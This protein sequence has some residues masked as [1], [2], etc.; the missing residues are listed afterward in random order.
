MRIYFWEGLFPMAKKKPATVKRKGPKLMGSE[1]RV[2]TNLN[3]DSGFLKKAKARAKKED[4][5]LS[6]WLEDLGKAALK[7]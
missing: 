6:L 3:F 5:S 1:K 7:K 2:R 4:K